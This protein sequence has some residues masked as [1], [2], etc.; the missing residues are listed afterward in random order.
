MFDIDN[1]I[2]SD[3]NNT[4]ELGVTILHM[5]NDSDDSGFMSDNSENFDNNIANSTN[6]AND[7]AQITVPAVNP[8]TPPAI[9]ENAEERAQL[10]S[11]IKDQI[12]VFGDLLTNIEEDEEYV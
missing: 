12:A 10:K 1:S 6:I 11:D 8:I 5:E 3:T 7:I 2:K 9:P 4:L